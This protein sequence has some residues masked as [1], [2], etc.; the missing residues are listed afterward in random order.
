MHVENMLSN[1]QAVGKNLDLGKMAR[2]NKGFWEGKL[3]VTARP[4][5]ENGSEQVDQS[6]GRDA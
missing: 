3:A 2:T 1:K 4:P 5:N 6:D